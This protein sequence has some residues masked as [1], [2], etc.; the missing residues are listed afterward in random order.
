MKDGRD[1]KGFVG[2]QTAVWKRFCA[3]IIG[4]ADAVGDVLHAMD[5]G[6]RKHPVISAYRR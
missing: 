1:R 5:E 6:R 2:S 4:L 3:K